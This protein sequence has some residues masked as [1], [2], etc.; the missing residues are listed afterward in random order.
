MTDT[1]DRDAD[2]VLAGELALRV[3]PEAEELT[4]RGREQSDPEFAGRVARWNEDLAQLADDVAPVRPSEALWARI[5]ASAFGGVAAND[6]GKLAFWRRWAIG[7]TGLLAA[8][9]AALAVLVAQPNPVPEP[10]APQGG[11]TRVATLTLESGTAAVTLAYDAATGHLFLSPSD[12]MV[13]D[14][15]VPHLWLMMPDGNLQLVGAFNGT[16]PGMHNLDAPMADM[17][18][19]AMAVAVSM[20]EPGHTPSAQ[21]DGPVVAQGEIT[22][23]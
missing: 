22:Q 23:L 14:P 10:V 20:E 4:A 3:L 17:A 18:N 21:P 8:S 6:N 12:A 15:R 19:Q 5:A 9:V 1:I 16:E 7:S 11:V 13:G 2:D